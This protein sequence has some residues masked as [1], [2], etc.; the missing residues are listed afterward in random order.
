MS[1]NPAFVFPPPPPPPPKA[2][3]GQAYQNPVQP[4]GRARGRGSRGSFHAG[5]RGR[6]RQ[7]RSSDPRGKH[8]SAPWN[9]VVSQP[10][11]QPSYQPAA[12]YHQAAYGQPYHGTGTDSS[13]FASGHSQQ[14]TQYHAPAGA[15]THLSYAI[16]PQVAQAPLPS[17]FQTSY[18]SAQPSIH[19]QT[20]SHPPS[21]SSYDRTVHANADTAQSWTQLQR[22]PQAYQPQMTVPAYQMGST[23]LQFP[24]AFVSPGDSPYAAGF[25]ATAA[26]PYGYDPRT[27]NTHIQREGRQHIPLYG[28]AISFGATVEPRSDA[29]PRL[30]L[31]DGLHEPANRPFKMRR[32]EVVGDRGPPVRSNVV[33][34]FLPIKPSAPLTDVNGLA[35][36]KK[37]K[38]RKRNAL[39]L[40]P[41]TVEREESEEDV[42]EEATF[43]DAAT[44]ESDQ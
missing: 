25:Q 40:T 21:S 35:K 39:G 3:P 29:K 22:P 4:H 32:R 17:A 13:S 11:P 19:N 38:T 20:P 7:A 42:D 18:S 43:G 12:S 27:A 37:R 44:L 9:G 31:R 41:R 28:A 2:A 14:N 6:G 26:S 34:P 36:G 5:S 1:N 16:T 33:P 23:E 24:P 30:R 8:P 10:Q 15:T